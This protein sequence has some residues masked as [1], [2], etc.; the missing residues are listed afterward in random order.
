MAVNMG[1]DALPFFWHV[2][3]KIHCV[4][5]KAGDFNR[6]PDPVKEQMARSLAWLFD[7][8]GPRIGVNVRTVFASFGV[9]T[10]LS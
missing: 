9:L 7:A 10:K 3:G 4:I 5:K 2:A 1:L 6:F 8:I